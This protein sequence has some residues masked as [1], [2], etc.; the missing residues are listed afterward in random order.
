M[1]QPFALEQ[2]QRFTKILVKSTYPGVK[3]ERNSQHLGEI[4]DGH[5]QEIAI[6][7]SQL[8]LLLTQV[9]IAKRTAE[10]NSLRSLSLRQTRIA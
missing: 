3:P 9:K 10:N 2:F 1:K 8:E 4:E 5:T 6:L 7:L